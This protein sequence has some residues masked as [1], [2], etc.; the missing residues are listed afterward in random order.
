[1]VILRGTQKVLRYLS[2]PVDPP[3]E[4]STALGDWYVNRIVVDH[5]PLL[6]LVSST[7]L[8][9]ILV[10]ARDVRGLPQRLPE[11]VTER[12][13]GLDVDPRWINAEIGAMDPVVVAKT[14]DRSVLGTM[15]DFA[16]LVPFYLHRHQGET[17]PLQAVAKQLGKT[18]CR[19]TRS[20]PEVIFPTM[21]SRELLAQKW[22]GRTD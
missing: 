1:M 6:L 16:R 10:A 19:A 12:L 3:L 7:S 4:S 15:N 13:S 5:Q 9:A 8:L 2:A 11:I 14:C 17:T 20:M 22:S 21:K 18:P